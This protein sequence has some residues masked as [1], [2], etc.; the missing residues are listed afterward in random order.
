M[1]AL[2]RFNEA[3][4]DCPDK[5]RFVITNR[6]GWISTRYFA[7]YVGEMVASLGDEYIRL[8]SKDSLA[9]GPGARLIEMR[10]DESRRIPN[11]RGM[12]LEDG[13]IDCY[14]CECGGCC[15]SRRVP[16]VLRVGQE[17][18]RSFDGAAAIVNPCYGKILLGLFVKSEN[19]GDMHGPL[20][21]F[22]TS[23]ECV[24]VVM[25]M[26]TT[27]RETEAQVARRLAAI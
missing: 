27:I 4:L 13:E 11:Q 19:P 1:I 8:E 26:N 2:E 22:T 20:Y 10:L 12:V 3:A 23:G 15:G 16:G 9:P 14:G 21:G 18:Y 25:Q 7:C 17:V 24:A 5:D 6:P